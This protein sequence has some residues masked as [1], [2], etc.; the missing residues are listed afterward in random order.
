MRQTYRLL[1]K[2]VGL[3]LIKA[4]DVDGGLLYYIIEFFRDSLQFSILSL[5]GLDKS[6]LN[7]SSKTMSQG[8][9]HRNVGD[10]AQ[11]SSIGCVSASTM[12]R[13]HEHNGLTPRPDVSELIVVTSDHQGLKAVSCLSN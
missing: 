3:C 12:R 10:L 11:D 2:W 9:L 8:K 1:R 13:T 4:D 5:E 7:A 6:R